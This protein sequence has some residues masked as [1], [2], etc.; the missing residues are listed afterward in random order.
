MTS[1][2]LNDL[3]SVYD[4]YG[5][6]NSQ[7][8]STNIGPTMDLRKRKSRKSNIDETFYIVSPADIPQTVEEHI[9]W[10]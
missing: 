3:N 7:N 2:T 4:P 1:S 9:K 10:L 5:I 8:N 6:Y